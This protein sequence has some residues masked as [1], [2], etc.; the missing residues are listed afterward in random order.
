L[1]MSS[2]NNFRQEKKQHCH[3]VTNEWLR[4]DQSR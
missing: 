1:R 2:T 4:R 3:T